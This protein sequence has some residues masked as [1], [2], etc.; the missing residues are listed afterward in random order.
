VGTVIQLHA[1]KM[2]VAYETESISISPPMYRDKSPVESAL[3]GQG[4]TE[5]TD[6]SGLFN[7]GSLDF[8]L[9]PPILLI[10]AGSTSEEKHTVLMASS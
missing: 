8:A 3:Y 2:V 9:V 10:S 1:V 4:G 7:D 6:V 5:L